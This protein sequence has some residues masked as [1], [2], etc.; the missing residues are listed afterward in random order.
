M[1]AASGI[2]ISAIGHWPKS[3]AAIVRMANRIEPWVIAAALLAHELQQFI[4]QWSIDSFVYHERS[5]SKVTHLQQIFPRLLKSRKI[6]LAMV[7]DLTPFHATDRLDFAFK[8]RC[9]L[10]CSE[11][12]KR[13]RQRDR[14]KCNRVLE[15]ARHIAD[16]IQADED[17]GSASVEQPA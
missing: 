15:L 5:R 8:G 7:F 4:G 1:P 6:D 12:T 2:D 17:F 10:I 3:C 14:T 13:I 11:Q 16:L 9:A